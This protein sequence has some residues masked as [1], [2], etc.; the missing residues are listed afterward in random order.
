MSTRVFVDLTLHDGVQPT[1]FN[2]ALGA[3]FEVNPA[4]KE[5]AIDCGEDE[6]DWTDEELQHLVQL[7]PEKTQVSYEETRHFYLRISSHLKI[8]VR[9]QE[10]VLF[11]FLSVSPVISG[12]AEL[13]KRLSRFRS[14]IF[15]T[16]LFE[17]S[18]PKL[19]TA[20]YAKLRRKLEN[21]TSELIAS[22]GVYG[23]KA[24][25]RPTQ[26]KH[27]RA[28][29]KDSSGLLDPRVPLDQALAGM[30]DEEE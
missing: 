24:C 28:R 14:V 26:G 23:F 25:Q 22:R 21:T 7:G 5:W 18:Q 17:D 8:A 11:E 4:V 15:S 29:P 1:M 3:A 20:L 30:V 19:L 6:S 16:V 9:K 13:H 27:A 12:Q 2:H 10:L